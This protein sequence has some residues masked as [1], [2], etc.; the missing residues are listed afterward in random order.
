MPPEDRFIAETRLRVRYQETDSMGIVHHSNYVTFLEEGRSDYARQRGHPYSTFEKEGLYLAVTE[1]N[2]RYI[3]PAHYE[4]E[5]V[6]CSWI[7]AMQSRGMSFSYEI[8]DATTREL[9]T[10][11]QTRHICINEAGQVARLP[12]SWRAWGS[13]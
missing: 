11:A 2:V 3:K 10:T 7:T 12:D 4:Q 1:V 9:L 6:V 5:I 13:T 8:V